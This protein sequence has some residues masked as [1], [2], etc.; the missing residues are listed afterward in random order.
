MHRIAYKAQS[1]ETSCS[2]KTGESRAS[3]QFT[4]SLGSHSLTETTNVS[5]YAQQNS[6]VHGNRLN[7]DSFI[8][9]PFTEMNSA[10]T[11][12]ISEPVQNTAAMVQSSWYMPNRLTTLRVCIASE[13]GISVG[14]D[15]TS[16]SSTGFG[17][18]N[19]LT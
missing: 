15:D 18:S 19:G 11:S 5:G 3:S 1:V 2:D 10:S 17:G 6:A 8:I 14:L 9:C 4:I 7:D 13:R 12:M 16:S